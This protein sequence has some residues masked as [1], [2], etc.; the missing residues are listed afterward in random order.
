MPRI[1]NQPLKL[2]LTFCFACTA[3]T[4]TPAWA[5]EKGW[6]LGFSVGQSDIVNPE[7]V[8]EFCETAGIVCGDQEEDTALQAVLGYQ[9]NNYFGV[10]ANLFD[11]GSPSLST[12]APIAASA[13]VSVK[14]G[15]FS[16]LPQI[17]IGS[18]GSIFGR[19]GV[20]G[21]DV[22]L[23]AEAPSLSR[24]ESA[25]TSGGTLMWGAGGAL[26]LGNF[27][28]RIEWQRYAFDET[29]DLAQIDIDT[30][31]INVYSATLIYR[32]SKRE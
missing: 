7:R 18:I 2:L 1:T 23:V 13:E 8:D 16:L 6:Y 19:V 28:I 26:N 11:L 15:A 27:S 24:R 21:G 4:V 31:D 10:E 5:T 17:P 29:L 14:G 22:E 30:P 32:F 25:S 9:V 3:T 20:A 12:E